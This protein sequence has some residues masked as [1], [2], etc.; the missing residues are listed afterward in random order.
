ME[1]ECIP[2]DRKLVPY[3]IP[4][5]PYEKTLIQEA[6]KLLDSGKV[7]AADLGKPCSPADAFKNWRWY[8]SFHGRLSSD[9]DLE[10]LEW[11]GGDRE[12]AYERCLTPMA[13]LDSHRKNLSRINAIRSS[14]PT[15]LEELGDK[16]CSDITCQWLGSDT[17]SWVVVSKIVNAFGQPWRHPEILNEKSTYFEL[18][19]LIR[20]FFLHAQCPRNADLI[21][22]HLIQHPVFETF[23]EVSRSERLLE[24]S[25]SL[26]STRPI[27]DFESLVIQKYNPPATSS[28][29][30]LLK[31]GDGAKITD[32]MIKSL[33]FQVSRN[34]RYQDPRAYLQF[35]P[36]DDLEPI[37]Q[38][39]LEDLGIELSLLLKY[40]T[41]IDQWVLWDPKTPAYAMNH[42]LFVEEELFAY[43]I[44]KN[45]PLP[46]HYLE[47]RVIFGVE[48]LF[49]CDIARELGKFWTQWNDCALTKRD[50]GEVCILQTIPGIHLRLRTTQLDYQASLRYYRNI[51]EAH[52]SENPRTESV[53]KLLGLSDSY[54]PLYE[55]TLRLIPDS[56]WTLHD[57]NWK[58]PIA[59]S[60]RSAV[61][62][63]TLRRHQTVLSTSERG[64]VAVVLKDVIPRN[65]CEITEKFMK[66]LD[67]TWFALG[68]AAARSC[69]EF[70]GLAR[71]EFDNSFRLMLVSERATQGSIVDFFEREF[72]KDFRHSDRWDL[73]GSALSGISIGLEWIHK[74]NVVHRDLH[75]GNVF[76]TDDV[77]RL[78]PNMPHQYRYML[79][80]LGEGK[81][82]DPSITGQGN[83][84]ASYGA[85]DYRAPEQFESGFDNNN[86]SAAMAAEVFSFG[87]L[88]CKLLEWH[89][90][91]L[92]PRESI[93]S[94]VLMSVGS[95]FSPGNLPEELDFL[96]PTKIR[97]TIGLCVSQFPWMRPRM[98]EVQ[99]NLEDLWSD[100][101]YDDSADREGDFKVKWCLW[102]WEK[103]GT[104]GAVN[105]GGDSEENSPA[106]DPYDI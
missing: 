35:I 47:G 61:Y 94:E 8:K 73:L 91:C 81:R 20:I 95:S 56:A 84:H 25:D 32:D 33:L 54:K 106:V 29:I 96:V 64:D 40:E 7:S 90:N 13:N 97:D 98:H 71:V 60:R 49:D 19:E 26:A 43:S 37:S 101:K 46:G 24:D 59:Q 93:P 22:Q 103:A 99:R 16:P 31:L 39:T 105:I 38:N 4:L 57:I 77:Y 15:F 92:P 28:Q 10:D 48:S 78:D 52:A 50:D 1:K 41:T 100:L 53:K 51:T 87:K 23:F 34:Q 80:D 36:W 62:A 104:A 12:L 82:L 11:Y 17:E 65:S 58:A 102:N 45:W 67:A 9:L 89:T 83:P 74:H 6:G 2:D 66:E 3:V 30:N 68:G 55:N 70:F 76:V 72:K 63:A 88:A 85:V 27:S 79:G 44:E 42:H 69:V 86:L 21:E 75:P 5:L 14:N 18:W